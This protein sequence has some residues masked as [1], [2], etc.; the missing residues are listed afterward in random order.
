MACGS[1]LF[2]TIIIITNQKLPLGK[3]QKT[4]TNNR[5][6]LRLLYMSVVFSLCCLCL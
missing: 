5:E 3:V 6:T 2:I 4:K 1:T